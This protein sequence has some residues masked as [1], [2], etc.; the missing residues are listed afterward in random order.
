ML[1]TFENSISYATLQTTWKI[2]VMIPLSTIH[3][4][5]QEGYVFIV[6]HRELYDIIPDEN[7]WGIRGIT[8][9]IFK[10]VIDVQIILN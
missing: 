7:I 2:G 5:K 9:M 6:G 8:K 4:T 3:L 1:Q 10:D